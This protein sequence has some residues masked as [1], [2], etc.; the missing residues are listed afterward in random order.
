MGNNVLNPRWIHRDKDDPNEL[1][2]G[3]GSGVS[4]ARIATLDAQHDSRYSRRHYSDQRRVELGELPSL[5][6]SPVPTDVP[7]HRYIRSHHRQWHRSSGIPCLLGE[8]GMRQPSQ[9]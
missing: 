2:R 9:S 7:T 1:I 3:R 4:G 6:S 5:V 8:T